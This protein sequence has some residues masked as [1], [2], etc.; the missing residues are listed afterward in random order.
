MRN[1]LLVSRDADV[2]TTFDKSCTEGAG[3]FPCSSL[4]E[5]LSILNS[6]RCACLFV[7]MEI[8]RHTALANASGYK[9]VL[10]PFWLQH[11]SLDIVVMTS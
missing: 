7:D 3:I 1:F 5:A 11:P 9:A 6:H 8:L 10:Q 4:V 2:L